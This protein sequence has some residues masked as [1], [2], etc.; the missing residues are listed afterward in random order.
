MFIN[1]RY[2]IFHTLNNK[3]G[4][5]LVRNKCLSFDKFR[6][7]SIEQIAYMDITIIALY[8]NNETNLFF[9]NIKLTEFL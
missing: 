3:K 7:S 1:L 4:S 8:R 5:F 2:Y 6:L 9:T